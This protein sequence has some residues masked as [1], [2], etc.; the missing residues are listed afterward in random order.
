MTAQTV[1]EK[2]T[3]LMLYNYLTS[4]CWLK[5]YHLP[6]KSEAEDQRK[7]WLPEVGDLQRSSGTIVPSLISQRPAG[8]QNQ[9]IINTA[10]ILYLL[11]L[12]LGTSFLIGYKPASS[13]RISVM[14]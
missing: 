13:D 7:L 3:G 9:Y 5:V 6:G 2:T 4:K 12:Q 10:A 14:Y 11:P 1:C 8:T